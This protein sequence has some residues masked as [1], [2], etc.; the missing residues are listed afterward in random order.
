MTKIKKSDIMPI[1]DCCG[2]GVKEKSSKPILIGCNDML[3]KDCWHE[4]YDGGFNNP[5]KLKKHVINK[6]G[7]YGE[8]GGVSCPKYF[9]EG[10]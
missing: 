2:R 6:F 8:R 7:Q 1:C 4:W 10:I 5:L 9:M 3:C